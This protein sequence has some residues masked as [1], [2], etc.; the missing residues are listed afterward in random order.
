LKRPIEVETMSKEDIRLIKYVFL[1]VVSYSTR[2]VETQIYI[3]ALLNKIVKSVCDELDRPECS[4][5]YIPTGDAICIA[6]SGDASPYDIHITVAQSILTRLSEY[7]KTEENESHKFG[8][9][10]GINQS[11][12]NIIEDINGSKNVTGG[13]INNARRIMDEADGNQI[14]VSAV[15]FDSLNQ[16]E[17]YR[18]RFKKFEAN[19]KHGVITYVYQLVQAA[20]K[21]VNVNPPSSLTATLEPKLTKLAAYYFAHSI[22]N[23]K[24]ILEKLATESVYSYYLKIVLWFLAKHSEATTKDDRVITN[25]NGVMPNCPPD[26][27]SQ[28]EWFRKNIDLTVA[29]QLPKCTLPDAVPEWAHYKYLSFRNELVINQEGKDKLKKDWPEIWQEFG[30]GQSMMY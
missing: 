26:I 14:L 2:T 4:V 17:R 8:V 18:G 9:R 19:L 24:F 1:D 28:L 27:D 15:V 29:F 10:I 21:G 11:D 13:G 3:T 16:R 12:D 23:E 30:L 6:I 7:N 20:H 22:K 25:D 5:I